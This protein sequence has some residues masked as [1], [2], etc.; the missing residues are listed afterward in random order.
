VAKPRSSDAWVRKVEQISRQAVDDRTLRTLLLDAVR[1]DVGFDAYAWVMTDPDSAVG[2]SPLAEIP[3]MTRL[4][5]LVRAK[6][7]TDVNRWTRLEDRFVSLHDTTDGDLER[8][9]VW[10][11]VLRSYD[12]TDVAS[13]VFR[14]RFGCWAFLDLWRMGPSEPFPAAEL[15]RLDAVLEP[16]TSAL[17]SSHAQTFAVPPLASAWQGPVVLLLSEDLEVMAETEHTIGL[18][19]TLLPTPADRGPIPAAAY[20]VAA[21]LLAHERGVDP[22]PASARVHAATGDWM[23]LRAAR[24]PDLDGVTIA[25]TV[26]N[27]SP[28]DRADLF[29]RVHALTP[30]EAELV[31]HLGVGHATRSVA[32]LMFV[33]EHTIQDHLKAIFAKTGVRNRRSLLALI[34]GA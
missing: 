33:S 34:R 7:L 11:E 26:E 14:D 15:A 22:G 23:S 4:P 17:R 16:F 27:I 30:R 1:R 9:L 10:R 31:G 5:Q 3:D 8:S 21:Q 24:L 19:R 25:V 6:Y 28:Q 20:N 32:E 2:T 12:V 13:A 18:L 29:A